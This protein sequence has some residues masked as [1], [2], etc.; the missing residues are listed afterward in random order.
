MF[1][2]RFQYSVVF[3]GLVAWFFLATAAADGLVDGDNAEQTEIEKAMERVYPALVR[4]YVVRVS[5]ASGRIRKQQVSGSGVIVS[6]DGYVVTNHHV[7][8]NA[9]RLT[10][11][12]ANKEEI[13]ATLIGTDPL[14]DPSEDR[15]GRG[16]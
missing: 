11:T 2:R 4:I 12:L 13:G 16:D 3:V 7:A 6:P 15:A 5:P 8:A 9:K 1:A 14:A 10:C